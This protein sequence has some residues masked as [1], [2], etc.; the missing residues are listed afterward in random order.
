MYVTVRSLSLSGVACRSN[1]HADCSVHACHTTPHASAESAARRASCCML[2]RWQNCVVAM[3][4]WQPQLLQQSRPARA[5][6]A[7]CVADAS[8]AAHPTPLLHTHHLQWLAHTP[9]REDA[10]VGWLAPRMA[11]T[12]LP[13]LDCE[14]STT[15]TQ[16][17]IH[18]WQ[19]C[20]LPFWLSAAA[21]FEAKQMW[22]VFL[23]AVGRQ[24]WCCCMLTDT[25]SVISGGVVDTDA[26]DVPHMV[27]LNALQ[28][29]GRNGCKLLHKERQL[30]RWGRLCF[31][32]P[33]GCSSLLLGP[34]MLILDCP[35]H[36]IGNVS[37]PT[38]YCLLW[39]THCS[40]EYGIQQ[41]AVLAA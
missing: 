13:A 11:F 37:V 28:L 6:N 1:G 38:N 4:L 9:V 25:R 5:T 26:V 21:K 16:T 30:R 35:M 20:P 8:S 10:A 40:R 17:F 41:G 34:C 39:N 19:R 3:L 32:A 33:D 29:H 18:C 12:H 2:C 15:Q 22:A 27:C 36:D 14:M 24:C 7:F 23:W 31:L